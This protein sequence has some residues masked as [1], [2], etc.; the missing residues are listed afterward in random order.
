MRLIALG[1]L[2]LVLYGCV[3]NGEKAET[4]GLNGTNI[5]P[6]EERNETING[7]ANETSISETMNETANE[8][9]NGTDGGVVGNGTGVGGIVGAVNETN[10]TLN[11]TIN[12]TINESTAP[13]PGVDGIA[14][15]GGRYVLVLQDVILYGE[16]SCAAVAIAHANGT[17]IKRDV[18]CPLHDYY[19]TAPDGQRFRMK[20]TKVAAGYSGEP[21]VEAIIYG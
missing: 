4:T 11:E 20:I 3:Q 13:E 15:G 1:L 18:M 9:G 7:T 5:T 19:W 14:F 6:V 12:E 8:T 17:E 2:F 21:W 10:G 16:E